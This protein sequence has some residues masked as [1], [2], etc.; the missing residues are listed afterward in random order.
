[1]NT[2]L[3]HHTPAF[4]MSVLCIALAVAVPALGASSNNW[5]PELSQGVVAYRSGG[6]GQDE[7]SAM[8]SAAGQYPLE[9]E[10]VA[11]E[12]GGHEAF[13]ADVD[14]SILDSGGRQVLQTMAEGPFLLARLPVGRYTVVATYDGA[15]RERSVSIP[16][17]GSEHI[18]ITW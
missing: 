16:A 15:Q 1:M 11:R 14:V 10:F 3:P 7:A 13:V 4:S 12:S 18:V 17:R 9:L 5:P 8:Q 6:I 2:Y